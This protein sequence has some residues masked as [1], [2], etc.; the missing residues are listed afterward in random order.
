MA[1]A[2][3]LELPSQSLPRHISRE[4]VDD[5][6]KR[7]S[8]LERDR[9]RLEEIQHEILAEWATGAEFESGCAS[10]ETEAIGGQLIHRI[11]F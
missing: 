10:I 4:R 2:K 11:V 1:V 8:E 3:L 7:F 6:R 9:R 5:L